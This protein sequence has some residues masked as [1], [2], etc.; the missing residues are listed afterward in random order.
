MLKNSTSMTEILRLQ[1]SRT[2]L[3]KL[4]PASLLGVSAG[5]YQRA[6]MDRSGMIR[7]Q[8]GTH[9]RSENG[10]NAWDT[11]YDTTPEQ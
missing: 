4:L 1:N 11:L 6:L 10:R 7:T 2:F 5:I 9:H 8:M 3:A